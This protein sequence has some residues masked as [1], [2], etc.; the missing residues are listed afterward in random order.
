MPWNIPVFDSTGKVKDV[1]IAADIFVSK[2]GDNTDGLT[3]ATAKNTLSDGASLLSAGK[4]MLVSV[5]TYDEYSISGGSSW[6]SNI[7]NGIDVDNYTLI[8][9]KPG[10]TVVVRVLGTG[11]PDPSVRRCVYLNGKSYIEFNGFELD[12]NSKTAWDCIKVVGLSHHIRF[13]NCDIHHAG[14][15]GFLSGD[16]NFPY[17]HHLELLNCDIHHNGDSSL[18]HGAYFGTGT[19][20]SIFSGC[21]AHNNSGYGLQT[22]ATGASVSAG[23]QDNNSWLGNRCW[24][25]ASGGITVNARFALLYNNILFDNGESGIR[26]NGGGGHKVFHNTT[27]NN[28]GFGFVIPNGT[29]DTQLRNN[30]F[31]SESIP[32]GGVLGGV[33]QSNNLTTDPSFVNVGA[34]DFHLLTGSA[35]RDF[36]T[37]LLTDVPDDFDDVSRDSVPDV[38][39]YEFISDVDIFVSKTGDNT[40]GLTEATAKNVIGDGIALLSGGETLQISA[41]TYVGDSNYITNVPSGTAGAYTIIRNKPGDIVWIE[42]DGPEAPA[43]FDRPINFSNGTYN[44]IEIDGI[45][46]DGNGKLAFNITK[47]EFGTGFI[48]LKNSEYKDSFSVGINDFATTGLQGNNEFLNLFVHDCGK[49]TDELGSHGFYLTNDNNKIWNCDIWNNSGWGIQI[50]SETLTPSNTDCRYNRIWDNGFSGRGSGIVFAGDNNIA[51]NNLIWDNEEAGV[52]ILSGND[53][54]VYHNTCYSNDTDWGVRI[55]AGSGCIVR[56]NILYL[57]SSGTILDNGTST[58]QSNNTTTNPTFTDAGADD[59]TISAGS[60]AENQGFNLLGT[61]DDDFVGNSRAATPDNGAYEII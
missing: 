40:D 42:A 6:I 1:Q 9:T 31:A 47:F 24:D 17:T 53:N 55:D 59:F 45:N 61:V 10:D 36:G 21:L 51:A 19:T 4:T 5:G 13:L 33:T 46:I 58:V 44:Y 37:D 30:I 50:F 48:R 3:E 49:I 25:N 20:D 8:K 35:A 18:D 38:G 34:D 56:N 57:N 11:A 2:T 23:K 12:G 52:Q 7:P 41:G 26:M 27:R 32:I 39:A 28:G 16:T 15:Q 14:N 43:A 54:E 60:S 22:W 29:S